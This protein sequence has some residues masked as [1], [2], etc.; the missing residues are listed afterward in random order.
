[1]TNAGPDVRRV[2]LF[3]GPAALTADLPVAGGSDGW[4]RALGRER[5]DALL[6]AAAAAAGAEVLQP[7]SAVEVVADGAGYRCT[8]ARTGSGDVRD[9]RSGIVIAAHGSW[10]VG[11][12]PTQPQRQAPRASDLFGFK[13]HF[14]GSA[15]PPDLMP[16]LAFPGGYGGMV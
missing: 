15:L 12:L 6:L 8:T 16:L 10:E 5:L 3:A 14:R 7:W 2:G 1:R 4:G 11:P 13:A 9:L